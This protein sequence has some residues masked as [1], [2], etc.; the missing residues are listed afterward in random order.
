MG[1]YM[2]GCFIF[3]LGFILGAAT[4][5]LVISVASQ[6]Q[7]DDIIMF[8]KPGERIDAKSF[9]ILQVL[10]DGCAL[11]KELHLFSDL[12]VL[13][14]ERKGLYYYDNQV[15]DLPKGY[16]WKKVGIYR[17]TSKAGDEKTV[18]VVNMFKK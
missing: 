15:I 17:Y 10:D 14:E 11:A 8:E 3:L 1:L 2:K 9:E 16:C 12:V 6:A 13:L 5:F 18:P 4:L 7:N